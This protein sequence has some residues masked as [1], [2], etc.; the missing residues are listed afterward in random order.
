MRDVHH[1]VT[2]PDDGHMLSDIERPVAESG[3]AIEV[4][5]HVFGMEHALCRISFYADGLSAL[6]ADR[7][8]DGAGAEGADIVHGEVFSL[9]DGDV[10]EVVHVR[11]LQ[12]LPILLLETATQLQLGR[13]NPVFSQPAELDVTVQD[14]DLV[15]GFRQHICSGHAGWS[16]SG[17][18][19]HMLTLCAHALFPGKVDRK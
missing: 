14:D 11:L 16:G 9:P 7:E 3:Q 17:H 13:E 19:N 1:H 6:C 2:R 4:I 8:H 18:N 15:A 5:D 10:A 12:H